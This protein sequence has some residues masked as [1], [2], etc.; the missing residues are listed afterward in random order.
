MTHITQFNDERRRLVDAAV[1]SARAAYHPLYLP[2]KASEADHMQDALYARSIP[3]SSHHIG[4]ALI[5]HLGATFGQEDAELAIEHLGM[6]LAHASV[7]ASM[8]RMTFEPIIGLAAE[9]RSRLEIQPIAAPGAVAAAITFRSPLAIDR[10]PPP[11]VEAQR[12]AIADALALALAKAIDDVEIGHYVQVNPLE[13]FIV[14]GREILAGGRKTA[15]RTGV[16]EPPAL[17]PPPDGR[18]NAA[19]WDVPQVDTEATT[20]STIEVPPRHA[21]S[22]SVAVGLAEWDRLRQATADLEWE[23]LRQATADLDAD[24]MHE[25]GDFTVADTRT[26]IH[27]PPTDAMTAVMDRDTGYGVG[28]PMGLGGIVPVMADHP[29]PGLADNAICPQCAAPMSQLSSSDMWRCKNGHEHS[30]KYLAA[31]RMGFAP[32]DETTR[33]LR[34]RK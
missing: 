14:I 2:P 3:S 13:L 20:Q 10:D 4:L 29:V 11:S 16:A 8:E 31:L 12:H 33:P 19:V 25:R 9:F 30:A 32:A 15:P 34:R 6:V 22:Q 24:S 5:E 23:R 7:I 28:V 21:M 18:R 26:E 27:D 1:A 17:P